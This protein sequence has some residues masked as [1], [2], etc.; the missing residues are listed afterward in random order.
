MLLF[1][2]ALKWN[3]TTVSISNKHRSWNVGCDWLKF[4]KSWKKQT[5]R[6]YNRVDNSSVRQFKINQTWTLII[7]A[8]EPPVSLSVWKLLLAEFKNRAITS[9]RRVF[10]Y[11]ASPKWSRSDSHSSHH[12]QVDHRKSSAQRECTKSSL[13]LTGGCTQYMRSIHSH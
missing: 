12:N 8:P 7:A 1:V 10:Q 9:C 13:Q 2:S 4:T 6:R 5:Q 11:L 3:K